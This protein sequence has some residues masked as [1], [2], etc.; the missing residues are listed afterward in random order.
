VD[1]LVA[2]RPSSHVSHRHVMMRTPWRMDVAW[3]GATKGPIVL[4]GGMTPPPRDSEA[5]SGRVAS[6]CHDDDDARRM[7]VAWSGGQKEHYNQSRIRAGWAVG[8]ACAVDTD[9][10]GFPLRDLLRDTPL[11]E[12]WGCALIKA[13]RRALWEIVSCDRW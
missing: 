11:D 10:W 8:L 6:T 9:A 7:G 5:L 12:R 3:Y 2:R 13:V 1:V 4:Q